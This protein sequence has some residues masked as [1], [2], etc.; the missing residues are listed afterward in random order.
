MSRSCPRCSRAVKTFE[1]RAEIGRSPS[2]RRR[3]RARRPW[4]GD[5]GTASHRPRRGARDQRH[6]LTPLHFLPHDLLPPMIAADQASANHEGA[7]A[8][9]ANLEFCYSIIAII[10]SAKAGSF[11][12]MSGPRARWIGGCP[13]RESL[14]LRLG[15]V[16]LLAGA[17]TRCR[18]FPH[19]PGPFG[20]PVPI[21]NS[22]NP[23]GVIKCSASRA[24]ETRIGVCVMTSPSTA[25]LRGTASSS[26]PELL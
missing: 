26:A 20:S 25:R 15:P 6:H 9:K 22:A 13:P 2:R 7:T 24:T 1:Q 10:A 23:S 14:F 11:G 5:A 12:G 16:T 17:G 8:I 21:F 19:E 3:A 4:E 18:L